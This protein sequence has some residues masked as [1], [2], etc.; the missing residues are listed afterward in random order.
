LALAEVPTVDSE[1]FVS[2][3]IALCRIYSM[4]AL[5]DAIFHLSG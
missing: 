2:G 1:Q 4:V 5:L 3:G